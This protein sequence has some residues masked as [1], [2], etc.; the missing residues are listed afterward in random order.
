MAFFLVGTFLIIFFCSF[1]LFFIQ[2]QRCRGIHQQEVLAL[3]TR[4]EN[5]HGITT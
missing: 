5:H 2:M 1:Y 3:K 4:Y